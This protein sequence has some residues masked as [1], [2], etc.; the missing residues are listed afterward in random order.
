MYAQLIGHTRRINA[1]H[2]LSDN[3]I[4]TASDD[5][6]LRL[7]DKHGTC[8]KQYDYFKGRITNITAVSETIF[9]AYG[10]YDI[11]TYFRNLNTNIR[12]THVTFPQSTFFYVTHNFYKL[13][14]CIRYSNSKGIKTNVHVGVG[15]NKPK[16]LEISENECKLLNIFKAHKSAIT[17][18]S[19]SSDLSVIATGSESDNV[20]YVW[21][22]KPIM[23]KLLADNI[24]IE[25]L[26]FI[27][28]LKHPLEDCI[29]S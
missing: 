1:I 9:R 17:A 26:L 2:M 13:Y 29:V 8:V 12:D 3:I 10:P 27:L 5:K 25:D 23:H 22:I 14:N 15:Y 24:S 16:S 28:G 20:I 11:A 18:I 7:W 6:T 21:S 4:V 19:V